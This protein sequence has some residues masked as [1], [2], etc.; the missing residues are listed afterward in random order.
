MNHRAAKKARKRKKQRKCWKEKAQ[1]LLAPQ[2]V[3]QIILFLGL[4]PQ[5][6]EGYDL[7][8]VGWPPGERGDELVT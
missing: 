3:D 1:K 8:V 5:H 6:R 7:V 2:Y 4:W